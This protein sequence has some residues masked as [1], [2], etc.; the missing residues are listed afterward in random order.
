MRRCHHGD[1]SASSGNKVQENSQHY[2]TA[3][4]VGDTTA[5]TQLGTDGV[6]PTATQAG[7]VLQS[8]T[9]EVTKHVGR[10]RVPKLTS[11]G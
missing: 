6:P 10:S 1:D 5:H 2:C 8:L 7:V 4:Y 9:T 3:R 11:T